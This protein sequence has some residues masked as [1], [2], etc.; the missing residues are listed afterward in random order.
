LYLVGRHMLPT[1]NSQRVSRWFPLWLLLRNPD[2]RI[3]IV[4][5]ADALARR[6]GRAIRNEIT[7]HPELGLRVRADTAAAH[8]WQLDGY[9]GGVVTAGIGAGLTGR[10]VDVLIIDDPVKGYAEA[11]SEVFREA[12]KDWWR[13]TGSARLAEGAPVVLVMTRWHQDDLAGFLLG[14]E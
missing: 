8:E 5:Y 14:P 10:P 6:W 9:D 4:S 2:L 1:H 3:A 13:G 12:A 11:D 7:A